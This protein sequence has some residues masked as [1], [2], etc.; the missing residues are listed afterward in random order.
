M[1]Q[2]SLRGGVAGAVA[3][4]VMTLEEPLDKRLF[5]SEYDDVEVL[6]KLFTRGEYWRPI[7][8]TLHVQNGAFLGAA[9]ARLKPSLPG[10]PALR[11]LLAALIE[12]V[13]AWPLTVVF[14]RYHPAREELP[15]LA[16]SPRA[17]GQATIRHAVFGI[18]LGIVEDA[19]NDHSA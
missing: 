3:T 15:K 19:L 12:H 5:D 1:R 11:G 9:Y 2:T 4:V 8:F 16:T 6:G 10:S 13:A 14:D 7:G 18:V 17:F